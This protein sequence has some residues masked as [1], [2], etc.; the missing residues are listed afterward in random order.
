MYLLKTIDKHQGYIVKLLRNMHDILIIRL[1]T[2]NQ[3]IIENTIIKERW[4][5][6]AFML[7]QKLYQML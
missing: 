4:L 6:I 3:Q 2:I 5:L 7:Q 1:F